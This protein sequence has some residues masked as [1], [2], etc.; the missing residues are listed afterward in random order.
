[1]MGGIQQKEGSTRLDGDP[2]EMAKMAGELILE[3]V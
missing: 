1:M 2:E 3:L